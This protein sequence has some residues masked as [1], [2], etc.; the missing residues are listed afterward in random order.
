MSNTPAS[1]VSEREAD[2]RA[3]VSLN[4]R[5]A[6]A[7]KGLHTVSA[8]AEHLDVDRRWVSRRLDGEVDYTLGDLLTIA[9]TLGTT[10]AELVEGA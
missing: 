3:K 5:V 4:V 1:P 9:A 7:R 10:V 2:V 6:M 8:F